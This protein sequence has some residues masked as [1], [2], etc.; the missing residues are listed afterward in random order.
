[1]VIKSNGK[2]K[3]AIIK[4]SSKSKGG[5]P[6]LKLCDMDVERLASIG[7]TNKERAIVLCCSH[8]TIERGFACACARGREDMKT[9]I[10]RTQLDVALNDKNVSMLQWLGKQYCGQKESRQEIDH[11]GDIPFVLKQYGSKS[12]KPW[13]GK[14]K[15][16]K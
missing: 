9:S 5:R 1:M 15:G 13:K 12:Q 4:K 6:K 11:K 14:D 3:K 8:D 2:E 16:K 10:R 7:C